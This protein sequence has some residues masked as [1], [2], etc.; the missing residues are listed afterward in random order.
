KS[1]V[2]FATQLLDVL[3]KPDW[4]Q[5]IKSID[6]MPKDD[7][8]IS[9]KSDDK[10]AKA[11]GVGGVPFWPTVNSINPLMALGYKDLAI[12]ALEEGTRLHKSFPEAITDKEKKNQAL[13][14]R[15]LEIYYKTIYESTIPG[16]FIKDK[17]LQ[18]K[19]FCVGGANCADKKS[20]QDFLD[21]G[22]IVIVVRGEYYCKPCREE[23]KILDNDRSWEFNDKVVLVIVSE[24]EANNPKQTL[25]RDIKEKF[26]ESHPGIS[27]ESTLPNTFLTP[28]V[29][30]MFI[31]APNGQLV[32]ILPELQSDKLL[33]TLKRIMGPLSAG[34]IELQIK[35]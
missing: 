35:K 16:T 34:M 6:S 31:I 32:A 9:L 25:Q 33:P 27:P 4:Q 24:D 30:K 1:Y 8:F 10:M 3:D 14:E 28:S 5:K 11:L 21:E 29:P 22:K 23:L 2:E 15:Y 12:K 26:Y 20:I 17:A 19:S 13:R 7:S 18:K